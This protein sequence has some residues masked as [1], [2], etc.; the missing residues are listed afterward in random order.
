MSV[1]S[2]ID[3]A[4]VAVFA[5]RRPF[6][7]ARLIDGLV[8]NEGIEGSPLFVFCDGARNGADL[9]GVTATRRLV[10][11]RL[12]GWATIIERE[13][14]LGLTASIIGGVTELCRR[15]GK[16]IV[17]EDDLV[18]HPGCIGF[19]NAALRR[20]ADESRVFHVNAY[21]YPLPIGTAPS[22]S[23]LPSSWGWGTWERAWSAFE[24][25]ATAL[26]RR[27]RERKLASAMDFGGSFPFYAM[28]RDQVE[29]RVDS[30]AIRWYASVLLRGGLA[31]YPGTSQVINGGMDNSGE[32]CGTESVYDVD[33]GAAS[34]NWPGEIA[35][36][37]H[38]YRQMQV[39]F[40]SARGT[41]LRRISRGLKRRL[42]A[43]WRGVLGGNKA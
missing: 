26:E 38:T 37:E 7:T 29:G 16:V 2:V 15:Y 27:I 6:H 40:R 10:R 34:W 30:W 12:G 13:E 41:L 32:H 14:N 28:L 1:Q 4:P 39:F 9:E 8:A 24:A 19:L 21:R 33:V 22:L 36:D 20:Y 17:L 23:R 5:Y 25:D 11:A 3:M 42:T 35:E 31:V 18:L 43:H